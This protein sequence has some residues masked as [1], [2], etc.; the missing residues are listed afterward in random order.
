MITELIS[1]DGW[2][3]GNAMVF[4]IKD[5]PCNPSTGIRAADAFEDSATTC[6]LLSIA[7]ISEAATRPSPANGAV[8][9]PLAT[10][11]SWEPGLNAVW[12]NVYFGTKSSPGLLGM[13]TGRNSAPK[14]EP[15]TTYY[16]KVDEVDGSGKVTAGTVWSFTT[17]PGEATAPSPADF[18]AGVALDTTLSWTPGVTAVSH[19]VYFGTVSP[20][21]FIGNQTAATFDPNVVDPNGLAIGGVYY[22]RIDEK[23]AQGKKYI[24]YIRIF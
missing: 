16:W 12:R 21:P 1:Q 11:L 10:V 6:P 2:V 14:L 18:A 4:R 15:S 17:P 23:D 7:A 19:D 9:V 24:G 3:S 8:D 13:T 20:P 5:D 22:W